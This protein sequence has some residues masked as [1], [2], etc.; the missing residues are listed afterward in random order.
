VTHSVGISEVVDPSEPL[1]RFLT[2]R[3]QYTLEVVKAPAFMPETKSLET[4]V[5]RIL[6][7]DDADTMA[8]GT[9]VAA[10]SDRRCHGWAAIRANRVVET[11]LRLKPD[12]EPP[13]HAAIVGW[14]ATKAEQKGLA[15]RLA[16]A[17]LLVLRRQS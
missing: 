8:L 9:A 4:S 11:G 13:G 15:V 7:L 16:S 14:P 10:K 5:H 2:S 6:E 17:S 3:G 1:A 12:N